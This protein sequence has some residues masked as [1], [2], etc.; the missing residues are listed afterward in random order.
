MTLGAGCSSRRGSWSICCTR[1]TGTHC[2]SD[3]RSAAEI[4]RS[5]CFEG[6]NYY[7]VWLV[8]VMDRVESS[9]SLH[10]RLDKITLGSKVNIFAIKG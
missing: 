4:T 2:R 9:G 8:K 7:V 6:W 3:T 5:K 1:G 10:I